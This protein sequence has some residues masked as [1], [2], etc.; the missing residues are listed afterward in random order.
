MD[1]PVVLLDRDGVINRRLLH[2]VVRA[3]DLEVLPQALRGLELLNRAH[4]VVAIVS[5]Q[6]NV[7]RGLLAL[8]ELGRIHAAMLGRIRAAGGRV[9]AVY[10]CPHT[11]HQNC[12]CRK[13]APGMLLRAASELGFAIESAHMIGDQPCDVE[14]ARRA[15]CHAIL[16]GDCGVE[17]FSDSASP[18]LLARDLGEAAEWIVNDS[19]RAV[20]PRQGLKTARPSH[21]VHPRRRL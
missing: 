10:V 2:G 4:A 20:R 19:S 15:G 6:A 17:L 16:V 12:R 1:R 13:P 9:D 14:A 21:T 5:N 3:E 18:P 8:D 11:P 7:G